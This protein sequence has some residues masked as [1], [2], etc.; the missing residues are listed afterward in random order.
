MKKF[1]FL[2]GALCISV[3]LVVIG[4]YVLLAAMYPTWGWMYLTTYLMD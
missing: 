2:W 4:S 1:K 3:V